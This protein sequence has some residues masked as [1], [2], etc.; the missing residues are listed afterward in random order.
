MEFRT[1]KIPPGV[2]TVLLATLLNGA[3]GGELAD[4]RGWVLHFSAGVL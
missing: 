1:K 2:Y 3:V 4:A